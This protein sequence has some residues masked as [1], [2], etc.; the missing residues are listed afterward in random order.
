L[1]AESAIIAI[2]L[3]EWATASHAEQI[4]AGEPHRGR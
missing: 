3:G 4:A 1:L 2:K